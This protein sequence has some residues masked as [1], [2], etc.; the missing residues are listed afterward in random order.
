M[1]NRSMVARDL[2]GE[3][4]TPTGCMKEFS[5]GIRLFLILIVMVVIWIYTCGKIHTIVQQRF[6]I[7][8]HD[9]LKVRKK[10]TSKGILEIP[11]SSKNKNFLTFKCIDNKK[12]NFIA[13]VM[14]LG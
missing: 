6:V 14:A 13:T 4:L 7:V 9:N 3:Y 12:Q 8:L 11:W 2:V 5:G 10:F 1:E